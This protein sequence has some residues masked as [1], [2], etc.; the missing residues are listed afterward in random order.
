M[1]STQKTLG[2]FEPLTKLCK[3]CKK[4]VDLCKK[5]EDF[6]QH[7]IHL[8]FPMTE[9]PIKFRIEISTIPSQP[10]YSNGLTSIVL[11]TIQL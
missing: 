8:S 3:L 6:N 5:K 4:L 2:N 9:N 11:Q 1:N 10:T 7:Q